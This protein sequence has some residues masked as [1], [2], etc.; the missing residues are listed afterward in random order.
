MSSSGIKGITSGIT[1]YTAAGMINKSF[2]PSGTLEDDKSLH[3]LGS[4]VRIL[5][6][7]PAPTRFGIYCSP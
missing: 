4:A 3:T 7:L 5:L 2:F 6:I 1:Q